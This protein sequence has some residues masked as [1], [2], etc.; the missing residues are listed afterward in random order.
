MRWST[1]QTIYLLCPFLQVSYYF[2]LRNVW[3]TDAQCSIS[4][5][6]G[7]GPDDINNKT[8]EDMLMSWNG[9]ATR[10]LSNPS[11]DVTHLRDESYGL[12]KKKKSKTQLF[13][14][15]VTPGDSFSFFICPSSSQTKSRTSSD[16]KKNTSRQ[17]MR[18]PN[19][20]NKGHIRTHGT[21]LP[22]RRCSG[23]GGQHGL[24]L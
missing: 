11:L 23:T 17:P 7:R 15:F 8:V 2:W 18:Q 5:R 24:Q 22:Q 20:K 10:S 14:A 9:S 1:G 6:F 16:I 3:P 21:R 12:E 13:A 4:S 19:I